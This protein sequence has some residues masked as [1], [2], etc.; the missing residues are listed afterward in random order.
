MN[1]DFNA[2]W[3]KLRSYPVSF[4]KAMPSVISLNFRA[5]MSAFINICMTL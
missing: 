3:S 2:L 5:I 4:A 1:G